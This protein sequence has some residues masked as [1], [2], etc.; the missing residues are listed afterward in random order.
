MSS[1]AVFDRLRNIV[2]QKSGISLGENKRA[3][4]YARVGKR[5]R[6]LGLSKMEDYV[7]Y[8]LHD[9]DGNEIVQLIDAVSTNVTNFFR[10][11]AHFAVLAEVVARWLEQGFRK[12]RFWSAACSTG[13]EPYSMAI[14]ILET[15]KGARLDV[16]IL[17]TDISTQVLA[18]ARAGVYEEDKLKPV[19]P[20]LRQLYFDRVE[21]DQGCRYAVKPAV[22]D[23]VLFKRLNLTDVPLP[24]RGPMDVIFCRNV[25]IYFDALTRM[26]LLGEMERLLVPGGYLMVGHAESLIGFTGKFRFVRPSVYMRQ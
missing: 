17:A 24:M 5:L 26:K 10:E 9:T 23:L 15:A 11:P 22:R 12:F 7:R 8:L 25:M 6:A 21:G 18:K 4:L 19:P 2:Y 16:K 13:E 14:Q 1:D 20:T 3:L